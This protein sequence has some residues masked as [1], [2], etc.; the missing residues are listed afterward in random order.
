MNA[1]QQRNLQGEELV[2]FVRELMNN[3]RGFRTQIEDI[4]GSEPTILAFTAN[5][6]HMSIV[7]FT[8]HSLFRRRSTGFPTYRFWTELE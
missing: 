4:N 6:S 1:S 3:E 8:T 2:I 5:V 7:P